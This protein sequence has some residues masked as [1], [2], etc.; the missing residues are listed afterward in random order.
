[1]NI[2]ITNVAQRISHNHTSF[3]VRIANTNSHVGTREHDFIGHVTVF[4]DAVPNHTHDSDDLHIGRLQFGY[5][6]QPLGSLNTHVQVAELGSEQISTKN[7]HRTYLH[8]SSDSRSTTFI[9]RHTSH[10]TASFDVSTT[11]IVGDT[12]ADQE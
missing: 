6:L 9:T 1:M 3:C 5:N 4:A 8:E 12:F 2:P 11:S 10:D 7:E